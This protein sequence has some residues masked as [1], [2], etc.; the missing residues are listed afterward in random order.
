VRLTCIRNFKELE[1]DSNSKMN[2]GLK[3]QLM[4]WQI[5]CEKIKPMI[6]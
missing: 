2:S 3:L 5:L 6:H 4:C 1:R